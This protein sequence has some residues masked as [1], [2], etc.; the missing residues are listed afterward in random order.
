MK[1]INSN[2]KNTTF[3]LILTIISIF[4]NACIFLIA[5]RPFFYFYFL[6]LPLFM[7]VFIFNNRHFINTLIKLYKYTPFKYY[8]WFIVWLIVSACIVL[9]LQKAKITIFY[10]IFVKLFPVFLLCYLLS[11]YFIP[12]Y[13]SIKSL[14]KLITSII[15]GVLILALIGFIGDLYDIPFFSAIVNMISNM[16]AVNQGVEQMVE[17]LTGLPRARG[18]FSEPGGLGQFI[19]IFLPIIYQLGLNKYHIYRNNMVNLI[20]KTSLIPLAWSCLICTFSPISL[21]FGLIISVIYFAK[22]IKIYIKKYFIPILLIVSATMTIIVFLFIFDSKI[23]INLIQKSFLSR[24]MTLGDAF[25][26]YTM[27]VE[28]E[29]SLA[30]RITSWIN[31]LILFFK[32]PIYG[33]GYDNVRFYMYKQFLNSPL[34]LTKENI[35]NMIASF[36]DNI[37]VWYNRSLLFGLLAETGIIGTFL[38]FKFLFKNIEYSKFILKYFVG[39]EAYFLN[40]M[41][42]TVWVIIITSFYSNNFSVTYLCF[43]YGLF[44]SYALVANGRAF[45][46]QKRNIIN[47][48]DEI[49]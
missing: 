37:G 21:I 1:C 47:K 22:K 16:K 20:I 23:I 4:C 9:I 2:H 43:L 46:I 49:K 41:I 24:I 11:A 29:G 12:K 18:F 15:W 39:I 17:V 42:G 5:G 33:Y 6:L 10:Y 35:N 40:G 8:V 28:I 45:I 7:Y 48:N 3:F 34:P 13:L 38:Y 32:S 14:I 26:D 30:S 44:C 31:S 36:Y 27:F 25:R 19:T